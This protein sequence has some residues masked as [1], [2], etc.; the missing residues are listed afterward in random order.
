[1][2]M[3]TAVYDRKSLINWMNGLHEILVRP[4]NPLNLNERNPSRTREKLAE[5]YVVRDLGPNYCFLSEEG[6][7]KRMEY[8]RNRHG[9][10]C[11]IDINKPAEAVRK[12]VEEKAREWN[13][14]RLFAIHANAEKSSLH[15][16]CKAIYNDEYAEQRI[17]EVI[18]ELLLDRHKPGENLRLFY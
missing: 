2:S 9:I 14:D 17:R 12:Y 15:E 6:R 3:M 4:D 7:R 16:S 8:F 18:G 5:Y 13:T 10:E 1:M 11:G